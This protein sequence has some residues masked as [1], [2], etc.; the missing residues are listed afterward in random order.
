MIVVSLTVSPVKNT[1][2]KIVGASKIAGTLPNRSGVRN[3]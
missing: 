2:G 1:E 3:K